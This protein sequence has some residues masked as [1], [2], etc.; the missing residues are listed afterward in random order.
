MLLKKSAS[1]AEVFDLF[2]PSELAQRALIAV[3]TGGMAGEV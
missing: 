2:Q 3:R 1:A